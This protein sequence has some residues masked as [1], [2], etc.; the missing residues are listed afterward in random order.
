LVK[1]FTDKQK[2]Q[3]LFIGNKL[4]FLINYFIKPN[5]TISSQTITII[6]NKHN[7]FIKLIETTHNYCVRFIWNQAVTNKPDKLTDIIPNTIPKSKG[8]II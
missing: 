5:L 7:F 4:M 8:S 1:S 3:F 2:L 6:K